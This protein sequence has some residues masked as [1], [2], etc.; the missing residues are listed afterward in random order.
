MQRD[1]SL[2]PWPMHTQQAISAA[3]AENSDARV[4]LAKS[5]REC[6]AL[7]AKVLDLQQMVEQQRMEI[8]AVATE[9]DAQR[10]HAEA[11]ARRIEALQ[12][13]LALSESSRRGERENLDAERVALET[14]R[15]TLEADR[16]C[17]GHEQTKLAKDKR[18]SRRA[19]ARFK[20]KAEALENRFA[21]E[22][23]CRG[24]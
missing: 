10:E 22:E 24:Y 14:Q 6:S 19:M 11:R 8:T 3:R 15:L 23:D 16:A 1:L 4:A 12:E 13:R 5:R 2:K 21:G 20:R 7:Q 18:S 17:L 9:R